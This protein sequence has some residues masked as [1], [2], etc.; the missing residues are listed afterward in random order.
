[1]SS[2]VHVQLHRRQIS[3][4]CWDPS[5]VIYFALAPARD[6][7]VCYFEMQSPG[8]WIWCILVLRPEVRGSTSSTC[9]PVTSSTLLKA[10]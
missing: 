9:S 1:M 4:V 8:Y 2:S 6:F 10:E 5:D 7:I 3:A